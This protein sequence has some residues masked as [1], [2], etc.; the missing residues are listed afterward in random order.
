MLN[1]IKTIGNRIAV[2]TPGI[3]HSKKHWQKLPSGQ[4]QGSFQ[5]TTGVNEVIPPRHAHRLIVEKITT[6]NY[7]LGIPNLTQTEQSDPQGATQGQWKK[8]IGHQYPPI[9]FAVAVKHIR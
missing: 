8:E 4:S 5:L 1:P 2:G 9:F 3:Y 7:G 6:K